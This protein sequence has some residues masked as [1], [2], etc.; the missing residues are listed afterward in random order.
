VPT[1]SGEI[2]DEEEDNDY[3]EKTDRVQ[4]R[5]A[6]TFISQHREATTIRSRRSW[7]G[8]VACRNELGYPAISTSQKLDLGL[9][10]GSVPSFRAWVERSS[11]A[12]ERFHTEKKNLQG[13]EPWSTSRRGLADE[14]TLPLPRE[15]YERPVRIL[16]RSENEYI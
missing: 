10:C 15:R 1:I 9:G 4:R 7:P 12:R 6:T 3:D 13:P 5:C 16:A 8:R 2:G 11:E 14:F